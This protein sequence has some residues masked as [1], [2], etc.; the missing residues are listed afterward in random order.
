MRAE[1]Q[2]GEE[3]YTQRRE[4]EVGPVEASPADARGEA[5]THQRGNGHP[6][7]PDDRIHGCQPDDDAREDDPD[8]QHPRDRERRCVGE[9][10]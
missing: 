6:H 8:F 2:P 1:E 7:H 4:Q 9:Q 3:R 5:R 10:W